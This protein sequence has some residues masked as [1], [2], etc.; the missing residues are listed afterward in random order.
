MWD[1]FKAQFE[2]FLV[3]MLL[4]LANLSICCKFHSFIRLLNSPS[5]LLT[6]TWHSNHRNFVIYE[7]FFNEISAV[8]FLWL[9]FAEKINSL[10]V[11]QQK[12]SQ[13]KLVLRSWKK[14][15]KNWLKK[16]LV[17]HEILVVRS[18]RMSYSSLPEL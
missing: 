6:H 8:N 11:N 1:L 13:L 12:I 15:K 18:P 2:C 17:T 4:I 16:Y 9:L 7:Y 10:L 14:V 5:G 3:K